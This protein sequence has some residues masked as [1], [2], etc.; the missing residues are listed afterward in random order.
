[1]T[2]SRVSKADFE[3]PVVMSVVRNALV[4]VFCISFVVFVALF[5]RLPIFRYLPDSFLG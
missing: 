3:T 4:V 2:E 1:M 5:G